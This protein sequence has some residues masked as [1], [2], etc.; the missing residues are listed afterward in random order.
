LHDLMHELCQS[1]SAEECLNISKL[2]FR[3]DIIPQSVRH[4]SISIENQYD[5]NFEEEMCKLTRRIDIANVRTLMIF[6]SYEE[7][8]SKLLKDCFKEI[9]SLRVLVIVVD[10][11]ESFPDRFS[12]LIHLQYLKISSTSW[13]R[14]LSLPSTLSRFYHLKVLDVDGWRGSSDLPA[15]FCHLENLHYFCA[16][17]ELQSNIRNVGKIKHLQNLKEFY[18]R[19]ESMGFELSEL[20]ALT[21]LGGELILNNLED[22][23]TKDEAM[24]AK[25]RLKRNLK[26]LTLY[27]N[28]YEPTMDGILDALQPHSNLRVLKILDHGGTIGPTWLSLDIWL[29]SLETLTLDSV[30][31]STLPPLGNLPKLK[32]LILK[33]NSGICQFGP[34]YGGAPGKCF[35]RLKTVLFHEM[36]EL[37][38]WVVEPN[39][40]SFPSL[41][42]IECVKCPNLQVMPFSAVSCTNLCKLKVSGCPKMSL[43]SMP[44]TS[45][46][47]DLVVEEAGSKVLT[48]DGKILV[49]RGYG[50]DVAFHNLENAEDVTIENGSHVEKLKVLKELAMDRC[51][52]LL[53]EELNGSIVIRSVKSLRLDASQLTSKSLPKVL[54]CFP[55][56]SYLHIKALHQ[57]GDNE[58]CVLQFPSSGSLQ[59]LGLYDCKGLVFMPVE[60]GGGIQ[61]DNS[62]LKTLEISRC[63]KLFCRWPMGEAGCQS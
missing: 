62:L 3:A 23:K 52:G 12:K 14:T 30:S 55:A 54:N 27:W 17:S 16:D 59:D 58:E 26:E 33:R 4:L 53:P 51:D 38:E 18:V 44:H 57:D 60:N 24:A 48:Y 34:Q 22:V 6:R 40:H 63:G 28:Y 1:I 35:M 31:W 50:G 25:L 13:D 45:T 7:R 49:I 56:L 47:T 43:P 46:L 8:I 42:M 39:C 20:G 21:E 11:P 19:E 15:D 41:E 61:E 9:N 29:T 5:E 2:D 32:V 10:S 36:P 37:T